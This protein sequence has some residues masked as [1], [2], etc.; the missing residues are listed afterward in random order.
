M[1]SSQQEEM[2]ETNQLR[3]SAGRRRR[4]YIDTF[5]VTSLSL[6]IWFLILKGFI[7]KEGYYK[8]PY[9]FIFL[10]FPIVAVLLYIHQK[11]SLRLIGLETSLSRE[12]NY[13][14]VKATLKELK[15]K[16]KVD[17]KGF[18]EAHIDNF[19]IFNGSD[20]MFSVVITENRILVNSISN[21]DTYV[22]QAI[23]W[24]QNFRNLIEF[25]KKFEEVLTVK[26]C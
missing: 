16:I 12:R 14:A 15:W 4:Y 10:I 8:S 20:Q 22:S 24:G 23:T 25:K 9:V 5:I 13:Q 26:F 17:N 2:I 3:L 18:I 7:N 1:N 21:V 6:V 19:G 11:N